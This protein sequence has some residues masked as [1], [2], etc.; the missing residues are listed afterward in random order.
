VIAQHVLPVVVA[1]DGGGLL[2]TARI[3]LR[4]CPGGIEGWLWQ[5]LGDRLWEAGRLVV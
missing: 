4:R 2:G 5:V 3:R 1:K